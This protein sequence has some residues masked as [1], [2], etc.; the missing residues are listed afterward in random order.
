[1]AK[2]S[3]SPSE[4]RIF[5]STHPDRKEM[6]LFYKVNKIPHCQLKAGRPARAAPTGTLSPELL[7]NCL[8]DMQLIQR[9][10]GLTLR[11]PTNLTVKPLDLTLISQQLS[12]KRLPAG[13]A[14]FSLISQE[15]PGA[16]ESVLPQSS[17]AVLFCF[18]FFLTKDT[19]CPWTLTYS[20]VRVN[21]F[22]VT[23]SFSHL[24][25]PHP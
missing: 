3:L 9:K 21:N 18:V 12:T 2:H 1:M 4:E 15:E 14:V 17:C 20:S 22:L 6:F 7:R 13:S 5:S 23:V 11:L 25:I 24:P 19:F 8:W 16:Q 10:A